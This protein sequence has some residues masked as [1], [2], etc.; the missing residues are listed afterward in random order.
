MW[1]LRY[2]FHRT[3]VYP[4]FRII[5]IYS[6]HLTHMY[7]PHITP[8]QIHTHTTHPHFH[9]FKIFPVVK[10]EHLTLLDQKT[11]CCHFKPVFLGST[12]RY[13]F[14]RQL[15]R[16][17][18][19]IDWK[20]SPGS[21][22]ALE[23]DCIK[24]RSVWWPQIKGLFGR[25][26]QQWALV[27]LL[28]DSW[29]ASSCMPKWQQSGPGRTWFCDMRMLW[30]K[31]D[32]NGVWESVCVCVWERERDTQRYI[33]RDDRERERERKRERVRGVSEHTSY[34]PHRYK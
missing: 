2:S 34:P 32:W 22:P 23:I 30:T 33:G 19:M 20:L 4:W 21:H 18:K 12:C 24:W 26:L 13:A 29:N 14:H 31:K 15:K 27:T 8:P 17:A 25:L 6:T 10:K 9:P 3:S 11:Q 16:S 28:G 5:H 1:R 7:I